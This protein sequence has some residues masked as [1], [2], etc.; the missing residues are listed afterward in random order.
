MSLSPRLPDFILAD[1]YKNDLVLPESE[2]APV[3]VEVPQQKLTTRP[4]EWKKLGDNRQHI[5]ILVQEPDAAYLPE[6]EFAL[7]SNILKA[8]HLTMA[9][10]AL[11]NYAR[12]P[13][14]YSQIKEQLNPRYLLLFQV[15]TSDIDLPFS[16][17]PYQL[18]QYD[19]CQI[20]QA[21]NLK[22]ML[23]E[24]EVAKAEKNKLWNVLKK[25]FASFING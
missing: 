9:D 6:E 18:Q 1:W 10:V 12:T 7:L 24:T 2:Q 21:V 15:S 3:R 22:S 20:V 14:Q 8:C 25:M 11:V 4:G 17:P 19:Q 23:G 16:I 13:V 5:T